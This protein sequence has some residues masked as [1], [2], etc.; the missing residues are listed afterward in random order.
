MRMGVINCLKKLDAHLEN[1]ASFFEKSRHVYKS[2]IED[3]REF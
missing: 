3:D 2:L 1:D